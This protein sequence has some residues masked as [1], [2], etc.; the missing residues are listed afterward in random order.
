MTLLLTMLGAPACSVYTEK[1]AYVK[2]EKVYKL[3]FLSNEKQ[4]LL[5]AL[6]IGLLLN[7]KRLIQ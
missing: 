2:K 1:R 3:N 4:A 7:V 5:H 6:L